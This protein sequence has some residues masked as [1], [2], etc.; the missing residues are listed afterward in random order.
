MI[1]GVDRTQPPPPRTL[2]LTLR[3]VSTAWRMLGRHA[4]DF[5]PLQPVREPVNLF[6]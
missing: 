3:E 6:R 2:A 5:P 4:D 1:T